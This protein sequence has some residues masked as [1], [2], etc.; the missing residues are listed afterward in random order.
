M[1]NSEGSQNSVNKPQLSTLDELFVFDL[2]NN[3]VVNQS[4]FAD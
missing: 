1:A 4:Q 2:G 3:T